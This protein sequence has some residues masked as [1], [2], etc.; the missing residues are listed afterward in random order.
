MTEVERQTMDVDIA[1]VGF[2][3]ATGGF[4]TTLSQA[5]MNE[6]GTPALE[7][8]V[9]PG[10]PLQVMC[11]ERADDVSFGVSG[12]VTRGR[13][14]RE[15][16]T[17]EELAEIPMSHRVTGEKVLYLLDRDG[18]SRRSP[19]LRGIDSLL[20]AFPGARGSNASVSLPYIP[21]FLQKEDGYVLSIGQF[22]QWVANRL[23]GTGLVQI[24]PGMPVAG[25]VIENDTVSGIRLVDQGTDKN[26]N[27]DA[28]YLPGMEIRAGLTVVGDG[29]VGPVG[30]ALDAHFGLPEGNHQHD[31]AVGMKMLIEL[32]ETC[33]LE[34][35]TVLHTLG[36]PEPEIFG[37]LYVYPDNIAS[38]G[39]FVPSWFDSPMRTSYR[40]LQHWM[41]HP[42]I[43][44]HLGGG[45]MR[46]WGAKSLQESGRR[47]EPKLVGNGF[48]RIGEGS[49]STNVL[50]N[51]GV[52][53]A[54]YTGVLLANAVIELAKEKKPFTQ[55]NLEATYVKARRESWLQKELEIAEKARDGFQRG[56]VTGLFGTALSGM[57]KGRLNLKVKTRTT[58]ERLPSIEDYYQ[59]RISPERIEEI[60]L[61]CEAGKTPLHD[62]L[63]DESGWPAVEYDGQ[64]LMSHQD[65]LLVGGK[66]QAPSGYA[67]HVQFIYPSICE[68]CDNKLCIEVCS[69]EA[70]SPGEGGVPDFDREKCIHCGA[71]L[72]NCS[73]SNPD[74]PEPGNIRFAAGAGGLHSG[75]N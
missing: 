50:T 9:M 40:Y 8:Q 28:A 33:T 1:C 71:C 14:I 16:F 68:G 74:S 29:P 48:A 11:Y 25:P 21:D 17:D 41:K 62:A 3:P 45:K 64:I 20:K 18:A 55:E 27:P 2:G 19:T 4:L 30:Q 5:L 39:I 67:D 7:S 56:V 72:W 57:T 36:Y 12:V 69:G 66:V 24:W 10:M 70:I 58:S 51:S 43:W 59:G 44:K 23:M 38:A 13:A 34:P 65:A 60:R 63:M 22:S 35:G 15:S 6:D 52:D 53:E 26:G 73:Q 42:S 54:W 49:G 46:S 47:G 75:E 31:W 61:E 37:F 32:P